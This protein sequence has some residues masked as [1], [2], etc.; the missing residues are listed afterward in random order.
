MTA[1]PINVLFPCH[2]GER[3][4]RGKWGLWR[5]TW[6]AESSY[7]KISAP[8]LRELILKKFILLKYF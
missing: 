8:I 2:G 4:E 3:G 5:D 7:L 1:F 6:R